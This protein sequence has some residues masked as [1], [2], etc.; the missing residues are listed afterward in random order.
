[1][2]ELVGGFQSSYFPVHGPVDDSHGDLNNWQTRLVEEHA[3]LAIKRQK[4]QAFLKRQ[5]QTLTISI[6]ELTSLE[7]QAKAMDLYL[8]F[9]TERVNRIK[10]G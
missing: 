2:T 4:L 8:H 6:D 5:E 9:L 10:I 7:G 1:M 3:G